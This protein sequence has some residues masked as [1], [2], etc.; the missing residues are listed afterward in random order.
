MAYPLYNELQNLPHV[1]FN[2]IEL[3]P[4]IN[5]LNKV[6]F[7]QIYALILHHYSLSNVLTKDTRTIPF[8]GKV[9]NSGKGII[10]TIKQLP[11]NLRQIIARYVYFVTSK[12]T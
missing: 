4:Q 7:E 10:Y 1:Q 11:E 9:M 2:S 12:A 3:G 6:H 8:N 5:Q